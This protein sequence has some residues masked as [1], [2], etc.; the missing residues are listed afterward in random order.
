MSGISAPGSPAAS[1][2]LGT[3]RS[4][5]RSWPS[6]IWHSSKDLPS[7][8][9]GPNASHPYRSVRVLLV[10]DNPMNLLVMSA[11]MESKG[12]V[13]LLAADVAEA[14]ALACEM[15]FDLILMELQMPLLDGLGATAAIRRFENTYSQPAGPIGA[16][17]LACPGARILVT[18]GMNGSLTR[19]CDAQDLEDCL[20]LTLHCLAPANP[21]WMS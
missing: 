19:P 15:H 3:L 9:A 20:G 1:G 4:W 11:M 18:H 13:P 2:S 8:A 21:P 17:S 16:Y 12:L 6:E 14:V 5:L 7:K 10:D